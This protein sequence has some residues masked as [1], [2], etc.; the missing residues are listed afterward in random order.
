MRTPRVPAMFLSIVVLL[1]VFASAAS[2]QGARKGARAGVSGDPGQFY[3]GGH[4]DLK[5]ITDRFLFRPNVEVGVG[6]GFT[7][8]LL[9]GEFVYFPK[10]RAREWIPYV[11]GGPS[12]VARFGGGDSGIGPGFNFVAGVQERKGLLVEIKIGAFDSPGFK[13]GVGWTW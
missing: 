5:E 1:L 6:D 10:G 9:N 2:A 8:V 11:G 4:Y 13:A 7:L 12:A 3:V